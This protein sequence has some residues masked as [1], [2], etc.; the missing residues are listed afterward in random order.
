[1]SMSAAPLAA[2]ERSDEERFERLTFA[3]PWF[4]LD[5][6]AALALVAAPDVVALPVLATPVESPCGRATASCSARGSLRV[7]ESTFTMVF[8]D[9]FD[10]DNGSDQAEL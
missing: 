5:V 7:E 6:L 10:L 8:P 2:S 3:S 1:M 9:R 4:A